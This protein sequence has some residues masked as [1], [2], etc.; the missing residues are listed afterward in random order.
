[1]KKILII[2]I[3][4]FCNIHSS[5]ANYCTIENKDKVKIY[6]DKIYNIIQWKIID[7]TYLDKYIFTYSI[8]H[9]ISKIHFDENNKNYW[10]FKCV[11]SWVLYRLHWNLISYSW[12]ID[13]KSDEFQSITNDIKKSIL[14][15]TGVWSYNQVGSAIY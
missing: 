3:I 5:F 13:I 4:L 1:M 7:E 9:W 8:F 2:W 10:I 14:Q 11:I 12:E 6:N 15:N